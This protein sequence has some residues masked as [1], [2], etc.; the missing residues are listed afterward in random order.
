[1]S[2]VSLHL[3]VKTAITDAAVEIMQAMGDDR[4]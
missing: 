3:L 1:L 2:A 4:R